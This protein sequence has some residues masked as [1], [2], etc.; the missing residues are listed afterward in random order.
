MGTLKTPPLSRVMFSSTRIAVGTPSSDQQRN[1]HFSLRSVGRKG[2]HLLSTSLTLVEMVNSE[3][4]ELQTGTASEG[5]NLNSLFRPPTLRAYLP[6]VR[7]SDQK[8]LAA[9]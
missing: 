2:R 6:P 4:V 1:S 8:T 9:I 3:V 7:W 5:T